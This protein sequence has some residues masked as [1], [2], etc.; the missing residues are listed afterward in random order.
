MSLRGSP[1][2]GGYKPAANPQSSA[3]SAPPKTNQALFFLNTVK[4]SRASR[5]ALAASPPSSCRSCF[6]FLVSSGTVWLQQGEG[7]DGVVWAKGVRFGGGGGSAGDAA[8][9]AMR[10]AGFVNCCVRRASPGIRVE[11]T[12]RCLLSASRRMIYSLRTLLGHMLYRDASIIKVPSFP[13][14]FIYLFHFISFF[15][16]QFAAFFFSDSKFSSEC[17]LLGCGTPALQVGGGVPSANTGM[18]SV[19]SL[20]HHTPSIVSTLAVLSSS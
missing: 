8:C 10:L 6:F 7:E 9:M 13:L 5:E 12:H 4:S 15:F 1:H 20:C 19:P 11:D 18:L 14:L 16:F 17:G 3:C 2:S